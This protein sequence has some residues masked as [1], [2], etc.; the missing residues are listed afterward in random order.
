M[1]NTFNAYYCDNKSSI[2]QLSAS[3][4]IITKELLATVCYVHG[5]LTLNFPGPSC[6]RLAS[7]GDGTMIPYHT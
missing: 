6:M 2:I 7:S 3:V 1:P 4:I 5:H